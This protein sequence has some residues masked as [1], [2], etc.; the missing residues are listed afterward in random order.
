MAYRADKNADD[1]DS[2]QAGQSSPYFH[3][4]RKLVDAKKA[5]KR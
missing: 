3:I 4:S 1:G 5:K 2:G